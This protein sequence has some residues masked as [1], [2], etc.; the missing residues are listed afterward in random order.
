[1]PATKAW[2]SGRRITIHDIQAA[3][4]R[5]E[6]WSML[7]SYDMLTAGIFE[8]A[9]VRA[10]LVGD[11]SAEIVLS[12]GDPLPVTMNQLVPNLA[13]DPDVN[14]GPLRRGTHLQPTPR[15]SVNVGEPRPPE[16]QMT[17]CGHAIRTSPVPGTAR[18]VGC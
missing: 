15:P 2:P 14:S 4:D 9:G 7:T 8:R 11:T 1:M 6:R 3:T 5:V 18:G 16:M 17:P 10:L 12:C 13:S